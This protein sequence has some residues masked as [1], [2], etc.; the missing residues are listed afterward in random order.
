MDN[1]FLTRLFDWNRQL[2]PPV[3]I[4]RTLIVPLDLAPC[5]FAALFSNCKLEFRWR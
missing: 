4:L 3:M 2:A 5:R 1:T